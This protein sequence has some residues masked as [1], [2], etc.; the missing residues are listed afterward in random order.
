MDCLSSR[1]RFKSSGK[2]LSHLMRSG[3]V[4][5]L[6][7]NFISNRGIKTIKN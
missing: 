5:N 2:S 6:C 1:L 4:S 3:V 7:K